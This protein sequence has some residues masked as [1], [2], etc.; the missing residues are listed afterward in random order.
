M[1]VQSYERSDILASPEMFF[2]WF[3]V[4]R[5]RFI[6]RNR[7][8]TSWNTVNGRLGYTLVER[9]LQCQATVGFFSRKWTRCF[10]LDVDLHRV[11][12]PWATHAE[13]LIC[14]RE[15]LTDVFA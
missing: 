8:D 4:D 3:S 1:I 15:I 5:S 9:A 13:H 2:A 11:A 12:D 6:M 7:D 14:A 10:I